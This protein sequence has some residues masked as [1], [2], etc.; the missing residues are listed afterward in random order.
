MTSATTTGMAIEMRDVDEVKPYPNNPRV[1]DGAVEAVAKSIREFGFRQPLVVDKDG[2]IVVGHT[3]WKAAKH[4]GLDRVPVHVAD[5]TPEQAKAYRLADNR[6]ALI[7]EWSDELLAVELGELKALDIDLAGL[8]FTDVEISKLLEPG[9]E[10]GATDPDDIPAP[11]DEAITQ[12]GDLW[13]L[14]NHRLLCGDS[15]SVADLDRL[16]DGAVI[17]LCNTDPPYN[18]KVEPRSNNAI[19]AGLSSFSATN[20]Q[21]RNH[22]QRFDAARNPASKKGTGK[23]MRA[24]DR[25]LANDF[26]TDEEFDRL[27]D[28]WFGNIARVLMPGGAF[29]CW[30]GYANC[31]NYPPVLKR[32]GLYFSQ[33]IIWHKMHPVLTRKDF[34]GDHEWCF[35]GWREGAAHRFYGPNN[36]PD[37]WQ[38]KKVNPQS[39][40]HLTEKPVELA[41]R[42]M[43]YS[44]QPGEHVLDLFGGSG[45]SLIAAEQTGRKAFLMELDAPYCDVIVQRWENFTGKK[46]ER[47]AA[48]VRS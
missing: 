48:A 30:G 1:N 31:A 33:A 29:F 43:E 8:G 46:A 34:M 36:V 5:L 19:A 16:L 22:H 20:T 28:A 32:H 40:V 25:P 11:P 12:P 23:Q 17:H 41:K 44:S 10:V 26:V 39:M 24:K 27:L 7:A 9:L 47:I 6:T 14:G 15:G 42:A 21:P 4:L 18:V 38:V 37:V 13:I 45:S 35:Y 3:R 2:V